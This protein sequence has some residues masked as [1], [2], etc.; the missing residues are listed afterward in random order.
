MQNRI[1]QFEEQLTRIPH[2]TLFEL[3]EVKT[4]FTRPDEKE[5]IAKHIGDISAELLKLSD[6]IN[7]KLLTHLLFM[8]V[9][10][11]RLGNRLEESTANA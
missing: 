7:S 4:P 5:N 10:E 6:K 11:A 2:S 1:V 3:F 8:A 9:Q